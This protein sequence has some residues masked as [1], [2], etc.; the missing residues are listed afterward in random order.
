MPVH[1]T[2]GDQVEVWVELEDGS[3]RRCDQV[4][5][6]VEPRDV[7]GTRI[8]EATFATPADLPLGYHTLYAA[9]RRPPDRDAR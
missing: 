3:A 2:D 8:G 7:D 9:E 1:V 5:H 6:W 4:D